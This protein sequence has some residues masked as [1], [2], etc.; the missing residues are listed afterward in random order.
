MTENGMEIKYPRRAGVSSFGASGS[1]AHIIL[2]EYT[3][4]ENDSASVSVK[5]EE[6]IIP[7]S[8]RSIDRLQA[9]AGKLIEFLHEDINLLSLLIHCRQDG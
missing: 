1:N 6:A 8:A 5:Y 4:A 7:L 9:Y 2:E 3:P